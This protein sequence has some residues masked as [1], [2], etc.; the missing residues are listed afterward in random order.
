MQLIQGYLEAVGFKV[1]LRPI[2]WAQFAPMFRR[3]PQKLPTDVACNIYVN[4]P[5]PRPLVMEN[6][7]NSWISL[8]AGGGHGGSS[9]SQYIHTRFQE[10]PQKTKI[11]KL[12]EELLKLNT[13]S[14]SEEH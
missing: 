5:Y 8:E 7:A 3:L 12:N 2:E 9:G 10:L 14:Y 1:D 13:K 11:S 6:I 4:V